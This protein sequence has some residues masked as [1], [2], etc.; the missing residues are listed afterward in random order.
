MKV[1][2]RL[3]SEILTEELHLHYRYTAAGQARPT[4]LFLHGFSVDGT[5]SHRMFLNVAAAY[6]TL[7]F[8][9][10][11]FDYRGCGYSDGQFDDFTLSRAISDARTVLAWARQQTEVDASRIIVHGQSLG[12][13]VAAAAFNDDHV[14]SG[15]VLWALS[16]NL[17]SRYTH[18]LNANNSDS[19]PICIEGKG[20]YIKRAFLEDLRQYDV[21][22]YFRDWR[23]PVLLLSPGADDKGDPSLAD[24]AYERA[25][26]FAERI[27][28][29]G[30]N[31]SFKC[32]RALEQEAITVSLQWIRNLL[33]TRPEGG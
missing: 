15:F 16:A 11:Q 20:L 9:T 26:P 21:L 27:I 3:P 25:S 6:N 14:I 18:I 1:D 22:D 30:A 2:F 13:A 19:E 33:A 7:G 31:H 4:I 8:T 17:H 23:K 28:V 10:V 24:E 29:Q 32:Q 12:T 5:E